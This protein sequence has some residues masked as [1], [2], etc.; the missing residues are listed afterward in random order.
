MTLQLT[1]TEVDILRAAIEIAE[2]QVAT[3]F[4]ADTLKEIRWE[5]D[6]AQ[7]SR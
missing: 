4:A 6:K 2:K 5:L 3:V 7:D 1:D